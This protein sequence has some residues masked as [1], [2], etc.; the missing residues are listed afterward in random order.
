MA[1]KSIR[2]NDS[3]GSTV[4][5]LRHDMKTE[6]GKYNDYVSD[7]AILTKSE[8]NPM[9]RALTKKPDNN[10]ANKNITEIFGKIENVLYDMS[11]TQ[12]AM[13]EIV[14]VI[15]GLEFSTNNTVDKLA[16]ILRDQEIQQSRMA[17]EINQIREEFA[18]AYQHGEPKGR[19]QE[20]VES[21]KDFQIAFS[22]FQDHIIA[23]VPRITKVFEELDRE[24][25]FGERYGKTK[26][27]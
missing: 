10:G 24:A 2:K 15:G 11:D 25:D 4:V 6:H 3:L 12:T 19:V 13:D 23:S 21:L 20:L 17:K 9:I 18:E 8:L 7:L 5:R 27:I 14:Q 22:I 1:N 16:E 26:Q